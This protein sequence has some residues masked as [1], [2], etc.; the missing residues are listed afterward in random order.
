MNKTSAIAA[1]VLALAAQA[2]FAQSFNGGLPAGWTTQG[3]AGTSGANGVVTL[4]PTSATGSTA[5]GWV[6]TAGSTAS[7]GFGLGQ[8]TNGST[9]T[10]NAFAANAGDALQFYFNYV[11]SD[12]S[13][14]A[15]YAW[16]SLLDASTGTVVAVLFDARTETSGTIAP[17]FGLPTPQ[18]TL[19]P[20]SVPI[21]S[22][23][24][25][26]APLAGSSGSCYDAGCGYTGWVQSDYTIG[27]GGSYRLEFG[28]TNWQDDLYDSGLAFDGITVAG[29]PITPSV[30]EPEN[31]AL[32]LAGL[33]ALAA[34]RRFGTK[35]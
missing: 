2:S 25:A 23:G 6:S 15:D 11:T 1:G 13:H 19:T 16:A 31:I 28:V 33:G 3:T 29:T 26:W 27:S 32:M 4:A 20:G 18:A 7:V 5:Y 22:G 21:I 34:A 8:E 30:P 17:G 24:P 12:G 9:L 10:S 35:R 14:F